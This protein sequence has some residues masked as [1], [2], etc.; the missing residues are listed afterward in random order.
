MD[1]AD[2]AVIGHELN[3]GERLYTDN[4]Q[5]HPPLNKALFALADRFVGFGE[6]SVFLL[7]IS[8]ALLVLLGVYVAA[9]RSWGYCAGLWAAAWWTVVSGNLYL[10]GN[11]PNI[12]SF[13]NVFCVWG[14]AVLLKR[15]SLAP[16]IPQ[17]IVAAGLWGL[18]T[19]IN[20]SSIAIAAGASAAYWIS[21]RHDLKVLSPAP[22]IAGICV[23]PLLWLAVFFY[24]AAT[25]RAEIF[26]ASVWDFTLYS[27]QAAGGWLANLTALLRPAVWADLYQRGILPVLFIAALPTVMALS[28]EQA[29]R[30]PRLSGALLLGYL[31]GA[32]GAVMLPGKLYAH[33]FQLFL[34]ALCIGAGWCWAALE[35]RYPR[36]AI[37]TMAAAALLTGLIGSEARNYRLSAEEW[38]I[39]KHGP[40]FQRMRDVARQL[41]SRLKPHETIFNWGIETSFYF[42]TGRGPTTIVTVCDVLAMGPG[43]EART[44]RVLEQ[45]NQAPPDLMIMGRWMS[46]VSH[47]VSDWFRKTYVALPES[48]G[49][50]PFVLYVRPGSDLEKRFQDKTQ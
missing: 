18:S 32:Y 17:A 23:I 34:P 35:R 42:Y 39:R 20:P 31:A 46:K 27:G 10:Q 29:L 2:F 24:F 21:L 33:Y 43:R 25:G 26:K 8:S 7:N 4:W 30:P 41:T 38:S 12:E 22:W 13:M 14:L 6:P 50:D 19:L 9:A 16:T 1:V 48:P 28:F 49:L 37:G 44:R 3:R 40:Q 45:L 11:L 15:G 5:Y 47:P 36:H